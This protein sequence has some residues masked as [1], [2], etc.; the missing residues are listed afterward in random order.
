MTASIAD[1]TEDLEALFEKIASER[2]A[3]LRAG[4]APSA[5]EG[6]GGST[7]GAVTGSASVPDDCATT[8]GPSPA[9]FD[10]IGKL[11]RNL[12][13]A[14]RELGYDKTVERAVDVL[15]DARDR[16]AYIATLTGQAAE[17]TLSALDEVKPIQEAL[18][19]DATGLAKRWDA[20]LSGAIPYEDFKPL[21]LATRQFLHTVPQHTERTNNQLLE[22]MMAQDFHDLTGQVIKKIVDLAQNL[23]QQLLQ[24]LLETSPRDSLPHQFE[25]PLSGPVVQ[26][27]GRSDIVTNQAQVDDLLESL[28]F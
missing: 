6:P 1:E 21:V 14:L 27:K 3:T 15:P 9:I 20:L 5:S 16:L 24:L 19:R 25:G 17:R 2:E 18:E 28:G 26:A 10:R 13:D 23:E 4:A 8:E 7:S 11:T 22:I 12:H